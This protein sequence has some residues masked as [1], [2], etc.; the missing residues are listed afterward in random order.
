MTEYDWWAD[1][2]ED[3]IPL[4]IMDSALKHYSAEDIEHAQEHAVKIV[5]RYEYNGEYQQLIIGWSRSGELL[6]VIAVPYDTPNRIRHCNKLQRKLY[7]YL[8]A[9]LRIALEGGRRP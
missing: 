9:D 2:E 5:N 4:A 7:K 1:D 3:E 8:P 6:E